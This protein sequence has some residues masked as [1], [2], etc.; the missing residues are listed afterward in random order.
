MSDQH[1]I[2]Q[3][4][5]YVAPDLHVVSTSNPEPV[6]RR[7][8]VVGLFDS[9]DDARK[10]V[11]ALEGLERDD[12]AI[13]VTVL[14]SEETTDVR[15][16]DHVDPEGVAR[17]VAP[18]VLIGAIIGAVVGAALVGVI[19]GLIGGFAAA[20]G[21]VLGGAAFGAAIGAVWGAFVKMG[22]SDAYRQ[23]FVAPHRRD[24]TLVSLHTDDI[25][26]AAAAFGRVAATAARD[27]VVLD[28][29]GHECHLPAS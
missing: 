27:V 10:A 29:E 13:G 21:G 9:T 1:T 5:H 11:V 3:L 17:D 20:V 18:R 25:D 24:V 7:Y 12:A 16:D 28:Q 23:T 26:E 22:G 14:A 4:A 6:L 8:N 2:Q 15:E 19:A